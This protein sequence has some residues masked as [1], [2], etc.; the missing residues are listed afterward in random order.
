MPDGATTEIMPPSGSFQHSTE[1]LSFPYG[2]FC[3]DGCFRLCDQPVVESLMVPLQIVFKL[4]K[5]RIPGK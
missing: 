4:T 5:S 1:S 3:R 2:A